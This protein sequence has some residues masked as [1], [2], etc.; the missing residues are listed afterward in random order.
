MRL[1]IKKYPELTDK[2]AHVLMRTGRTGGKTGT[3]Y[4]TRNPNASGG[5]IHRKKQKSW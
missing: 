3:V 1:E 4:R 2:A 5:F